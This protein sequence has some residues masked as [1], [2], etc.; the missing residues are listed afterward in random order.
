MSMVELTVKR[1]VKCLNQA[2]AWK[3]E[4]PMGDEPSMR[5]FVY[6]LLNLKIIK[7]QFSS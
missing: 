1:F 4:T 7:R 5:K 2:E 6:F 3:T